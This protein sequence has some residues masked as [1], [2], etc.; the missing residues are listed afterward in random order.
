MLKRARR[1]HLFGADIRPL[2]EPRSIGR[3]LSSEEKLKLL[4]TAGQNEEWQ[5]AEAAMALALCTTMRGCEIRRLKWQDIDFLNRTILVRTSKTEAGQRVIPMNPQALEIVIRLRERAKEFGGTEPQ[6]YVFP[7]CQHGHIDPTRPQATFR[8][9]WRNLTRAIQCPACRKFQKPG[10]SCTNTDARPASK[11][12]R[13]LLPGCASMICDTTPLQNWPNP[14]SRSNHHGYCRARQPE[15]AGP[16]FARAK[17]SQAAGCA[18][19]SAKPTG[20]WFSGGRSRGYDT[21]HD[22]N[23]VQDGCTC[24]K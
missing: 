17:R 22:T 7:A 15:D 5:R 3:A 21:N 19:L 12:L 10:E 1:W 24:R 9:A 16:V 14:R 23:P 18:A 8:T 2:K 20:S 11:I 13:A 6:H 4:R